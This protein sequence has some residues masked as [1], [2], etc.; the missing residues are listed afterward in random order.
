MDTTLVGRDTGRELIEMLSLCRT[1]ARYCSISPPT[2]SSAGQGRPL[3]N[4][5]RS[6]GI[7]ELDD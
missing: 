2:E 6:A 7:S 3:P 5:F 4:L 1:A